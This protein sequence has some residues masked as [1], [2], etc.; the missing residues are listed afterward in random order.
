MATL[1][2]SHRVEDYQKWRPYF[3]RDVPRRKKYGMSNEKVYRSA[4][5]PNNIYIVS[6]LVDPSVTEMIGKDEEL[7]ALMKESG[8]ISKPVVTVLNLT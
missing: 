8:V 2:L 4:E 3:D 1:I 6:D 5:D 7:A